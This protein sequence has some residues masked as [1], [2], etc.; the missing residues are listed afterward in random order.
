MSKDANPEAAT[1]A[2]A[3]SENRTRETNRCGIAQ[4]KKQY[5]ERRNHS[6]EGLPLG[7]V[8]GDMRPGVMP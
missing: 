2:S 6:Q 1:P 5:N 7:S 4:Q 3:K 8:E